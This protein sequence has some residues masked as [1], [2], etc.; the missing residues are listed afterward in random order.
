MVDICSQERGE[1]GI[2]QRR[3]WVTLVLPV[4]ANKLSISR[5]KRSL[6]RYDIGLAAVPQN[7]LPAEWYMPHRFI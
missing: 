1:T 3:L 2:L 6:S 7:S 4:S 5:A